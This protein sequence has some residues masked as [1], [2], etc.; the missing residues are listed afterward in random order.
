MG[1]ANLFQ[2]LELK[3]NLKIIIIKPPL[4]YI[5]KLS[6]PASIVIEEVWKGLK[7][8]YIKL[9]ENRGLLARL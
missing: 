7:F 4:D 9:Q 8:V 1:S 5:T 6:I 3:D 2:K